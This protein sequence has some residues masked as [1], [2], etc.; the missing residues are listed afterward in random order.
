MT[1]GKL[2]IFIIVAVTLFIVGYFLFGNYSDGVRAGTMIKFSKKGYIFK[3]YE[4]Q[5]NLGMILNE[6]NQNS[7]PTAVA[8]VWDFSVK[9]NKEEVVNVL[10]EALLTGKRVKLYYHEKF[11]HLFFRG[12]TKYFIYKAE[13]LK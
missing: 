3:T 4:G 1:K 11:F 9:A 6:P 13:L 12:D 8:S 10:Q 5:L 7:S 2:I